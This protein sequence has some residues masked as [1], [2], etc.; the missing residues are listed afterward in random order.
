MGEF[1]ITDDIFRV[2][3]TFLLLLLILLVAAMLHTVRYGMA[4]IYNWDGERYCYL[5]YAPI[6]REGGGF[7]LRISERMVDLSRTTR[8]RICPGRAF[9]RKNRYRDIYVYAD[10][11]RNYLVVEN[12]PMKTEIPF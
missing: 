2:M 7:S 6:R 1:M 3:M 4:R 9:C 11:S 12:G 8:Y 5:G 10:G